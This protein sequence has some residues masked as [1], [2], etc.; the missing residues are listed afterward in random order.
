M[1]E[2]Q[3]LAVGLEY[4]AATLEDLP[5]EGRARRWEAKL[6]SEIEETYRAWHKYRAIT[7][8]F[9]LREKGPSTEVDLI[10]LRF[11]G[12]DAYDDVF[13]KQQVKE[14]YNKHDNIFFILKGVSDSVIREAIVYEARR[15][16]L[17]SGDTV[18]EVGSRETATMLQKLH[19]ATKRM[20]RQI[21]KLTAPHKQGPN[22]QL[23]EMLHSE[24]K[25][26]RDHLDSL[27]P[28]FEAHPES[29]RRLAPAMTRAAEGL[30]KEYNLISGYTDHQRNAHDVIV[31]ADTIEEKKGKLEGGLFSRVLTQFQAILDIFATDKSFG[32]LRAYIPGVAESSA[33]LF[34]DIEPKAG[35]DAVDEE[36]RQ[37]LIE[38]IQE[39]LKAV[40]L[41]NV[42]LDDEDSERLESITRD[43]VDQFDR[44]E[45]AEYI[46]K[47]MK[48]I[49]PKA[50]DESET[51]RVF[52]PSRSYATTYA[53]G[54][55]KKIGRVYA[56]IREKRATPQETL[57]IIKGELIAAN[58]DSV[59]AEH[60]FEVALYDDDDERTRNTQKVYYKA[61]PELDNRVKKSLQSDVK[62]RIE[63]EGRKWYFIRWLRP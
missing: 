32:S 33:I 62:L 30:F 52:I 5:V 3:S 21:G 35:A 19:D 11:S 57:R 22:K 46:A 4:I 16:W 42:D 24:W 45:T 6:L 12:Q 47:A 61:S 51:L 31:T 49:P 36:A 26:L 7:V 40:E 48:N 34:I 53:V 9:F 50:S 20:T 56:K 14:L 13:Q 58:T 41:A 2:L 1:S 23:A 43:F 10:V 55:E 27:D 44:P 63:A 60:T 38:R 28:L 37:H 17:W 59:K 54:D 29:R 8:S 18:L 15:E 39:A 25:F